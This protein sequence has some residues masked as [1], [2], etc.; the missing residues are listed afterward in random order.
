[1]QLAALDQAC[2]HTLLDAARE[3]LLEDFRS[4][5]P[6]RFAQDTMVGNLVLEPEAEKPKIVQAQRNNAHQFALARHVVQK[7]Q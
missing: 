6:P 4:P 1:V 3:E 5:A 7:E 2:G